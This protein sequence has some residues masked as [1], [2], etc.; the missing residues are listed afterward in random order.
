MTVL[1]V[2]DLLATV[3]AGCRPD[4]QFAHAPALQ[5][6]TLSAAEQLVDQLKGTVVQCLVIIELSELRVRT[7]ARFARLTRPLRAGSQQCQGSRSLPVPHVNVRRLAQ[8]FQIRTLCGSHTQSLCVS[9]RTPKSKHNAAAGAA[10]IRRREPLEAR[11]R[12]H[13][14]RRRETLQAA[15]L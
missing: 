4:S 13:C 7:G 10:V 3:S 8:M 5:G 11:A 12:R 1:L 2:D 6:G 15:A 14:A 9:Y